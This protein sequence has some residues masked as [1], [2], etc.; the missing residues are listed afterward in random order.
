[1]LAVLFFKQPLQYKWMYMYFYELAI[2]V[3][4][5]FC[6]DKS[7]ICLLSSFHNS[8]NLKYT[9]YDHVN[10][11]WR[12]T[13][14]FMILGWGPFLF[15]SVWSSLAA[16]SIIFNYTTGCC[17]SVDNTHRYLPSIHGRITLSLNT[18]NC[19]LLIYMVQRWVAKKIT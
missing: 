5:T 10:Y 4:N 2:P 8:S 12:K 7:I 18:T 14:I 17:V 3:S 16:M 11:K 15:H 6:N 19:S 1:M 13:W 9:G